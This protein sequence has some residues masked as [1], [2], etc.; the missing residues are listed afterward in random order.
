[1]VIYMLIP[2]CP[3]LYDTNAHIQAPST[4]VWTVGK[5][6]IPHSYAQLYCNAI[7]LFIP[8]IHHAE[9]WHNQLMCNGFFKFTIC[10]FAVSKFGKAVEN[11]VDSLASYWVCTQQSASG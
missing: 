9:S 5:A 3:P 8:S 7:S 10:E 1:M 4:P 11:A 2:R 6:A